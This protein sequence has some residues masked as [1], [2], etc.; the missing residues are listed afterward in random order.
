MPANEISIICLLHLLKLVIN[1]MSLNKD[2]NDSEQ[3]Y[4]KALNQNKIEEAMMQNFEIKIPLV[5]FSEDLGSL[6]MSEMKNTKIDKIFEN[7]NAKMYMK[8]LSSNMLQYEVS[9]KDKVFYF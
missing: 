3:R 7:Q 5:S 4:L 2:D 8:H 1:N 6:F 9:K